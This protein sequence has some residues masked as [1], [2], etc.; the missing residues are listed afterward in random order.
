LIEP[1]GGPN[2]P[3]PQ[4]RNFSFWSRDNSGSDLFKSPLPVLGV[5]TGNE[6]AHGRK[7]D[8]CEAFGCEGDPRAPSDAS[9]AGMAGSLHGPFP[10]LGLGWKYSFQFFH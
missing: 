3:S 7:T 1:Q 5:P 6:F 8:T 4:H 10:P 2:D 9:R